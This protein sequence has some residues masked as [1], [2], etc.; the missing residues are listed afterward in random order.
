LSLE[1]HA[2]ARRAFARIQEHIRRRHHQRD[3]GR[4]EL[5][6]EQR[7]GAALVKRREHRT[8]SHDDEAMSDPLAMK[9]R[10]DGFENTQTLLRRYST[11][12]EDRRPPVRYVPLVAHVIRAM[13]WR[14]RAHVD[15]AWPHR[16]R[17]WKPAA[18]R[19]PP[20]EIL[21]RQEHLAAPT[22]DPP[23]KLRPQAGAARPDPFVK[24]ADQRQAELSGKM[25]SQQTGRSGCRHVHGVN[26]V[27]QQ[28]RT[29][30]AVPVHQAAT[31]SAMVRRVD[32]EI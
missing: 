2:A 13:R 22:V 11:R 17:S 32:F 4:R 12:Y 29:R 16:S 31:H 25:A 23:E 15:A 5:T 10:A 14:E 18:R 8:G 6:R 26:A 21:G 28:F 9:K 1:Q 3:L 30:L 7:V 24:T 27:A 19:E 20:R